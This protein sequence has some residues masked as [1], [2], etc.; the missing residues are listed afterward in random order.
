MFLRRIPPP[1]LG[2]L[3]LIRSVLVTPTRVLVWPPQPEPSNSVTRRYSDRLDGII[4][5]QF[6]DEEDKLHVSCPHAVDPSS[7]QMLDSTRAADAES[8]EVGLLARVRRALQHGLQIGGQ[9]FLPVASSSS[10]QK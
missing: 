6:T 9:N 10:Q 7:W 5:V 1:V 8:P 3:V 2:H 4:R